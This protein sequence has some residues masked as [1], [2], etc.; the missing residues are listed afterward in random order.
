M[1]GLR[2]GIRSVVLAGLII[3]VLGAAAVQEVT[4]QEFEAALVRIG[5]LEQNTAALGQAGTTLAARVAA[6]EQRTSPATV[7]PIV[8]RARQAAQA[9]QSGEAPPL[10]RAGHVRFLGAQIHTEDMGPFRIEWVD[11]HNDEDGDLIAVGRI[12]HVGGQGREYA[13]AHFQIWVYDRPGLQ[14]EDLHEGFDIAD[15]GPGTARFF[16]DV[17]LGEAPAHAVR[18]VKISCSNPRAQD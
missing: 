9:Q 2:S 6:L 11:L 14:G 15:F 18:S 12:R 4:R 13:W 1:S 17:Q 3:A 5:V 7:Q 16:T 10:L 8:Q